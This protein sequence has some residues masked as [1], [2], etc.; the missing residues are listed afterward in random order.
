M[1]E[2]FGYNFQIFSYYFSLWNWN[3]EITNEVYPGKIKFKASKYKLF[4]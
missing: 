2:T 1:D 3:E 4:S